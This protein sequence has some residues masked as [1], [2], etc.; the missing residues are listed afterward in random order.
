MTLCLCKIRVSAKQTQSRTVFYILVV[1]HNM[2]PSAVMY[3]VL[4]LLGSGSVASGITLKTKKKHTNWV[5]FLVAIGVM[6]IVFAGI[7]FTMLPSYWWLA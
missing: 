4:L 7:M 6:V 1:S 2:H 3:I 5:G